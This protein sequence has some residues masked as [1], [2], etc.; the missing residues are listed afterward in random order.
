LYAVHHTVTIT[1]RS[2]AE[3]GLEAVVPQ[4]SGRPGFVAGYWMAITAGQG[5]ALVVF[6][7]EETARNFA[8]FLRSATD[9]L[10]VLLDRESI[11]VC[12]VFAHA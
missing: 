11:K 3:A 12:E 10:G 1:D 2:A 6:D 4:V 5:L 9:G 7:A 8:E